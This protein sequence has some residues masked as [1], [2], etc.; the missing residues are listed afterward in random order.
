MGNFPEMSG[1]R[2]SLL[3]IESVFSNLVQRNYYCTFKIFMLI[4]ITAFS[5]KSFTTKGIQNKYVAP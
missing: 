1:L 3:N 5:H 4:Q 2:G